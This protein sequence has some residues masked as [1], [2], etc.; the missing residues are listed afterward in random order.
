MV[1]NAIGSITE[2]VH[3]SLE[4]SYK[5][6]SSPQQFT[7]ISLQN[8]TSIKPL[9]AQ[10]YEVINITNGNGGGTQVII[11]PPDKPNG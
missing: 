7:N 4:K 11:K 9:M 2:T 8:K 5:K 10:P 3:Q 6:L 1:H